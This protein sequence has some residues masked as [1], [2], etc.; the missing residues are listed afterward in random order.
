MILFYSS[1][2]ERRR[3][4]CPTYHNDHHYRHG[5]PSQHMKVGSNGVEY[6]NKMEKSEYRN[7]GNSNT[8]KCCTNIDT[9]MKKRRHSFNITDTDLDVPTP[10]PPPHATNV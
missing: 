10:P 2:S 5:Y 6:S 9:Y 1:I 3:S 7:S 8:Q 4:H